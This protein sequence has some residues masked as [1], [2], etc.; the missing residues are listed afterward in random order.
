M[1]EGYRQR[2]GTVQLSPTQI[3]NP[4]MVANLKQLAADQTNSEKQRTMLEQAQAG[5]KISD[6]YEKRA[7]ALSD[8][9]FGK[10]SQF[11]RESLHSDKTIEAESDEEQDVELLYR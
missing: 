4:Q 2:L 9:H 3:L 5:R 1:A 10:P 7:Y 8:T 6:D 11:K